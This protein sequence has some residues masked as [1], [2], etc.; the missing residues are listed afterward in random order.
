MTQTTV[1]D[2]TLGLT[3]ADRV[4]VSVT[5]LNA[6]VGV[7]GYGVQVTGNLG[8]EV[9]AATGTNDSRV[10][11]ASVGSGLGTTVAL[12]PVS[13][14]L[15][16]GALGV[17]QAFGK[18]SGGNS[19]TP[20]QDWTTVGR[21]FDVHLPD[22]DSV[23][24]GLR[25]RH[26]ARCRRSGPGCRD[27]LHAHPEPGEQQR[28]RPDR[29]RSVLRSLVN[30]LSGSIGGSGWGVT[31]SGNLTVAALAATGGDTRHWLA[32]YGNGLGLQVDLAP[33]TI[34]G[35]AAT[36]E[37]N[38][39]TG[40]T[41]VIS[42]WSTVGLSGLPPF[43][44]SGAYLDVNGT[45]T[46]ITIT[47]LGTISVPS[48]DLSRTDNLFTHPSGRNRP[49]RHTLHPH[50][51]RGSPSTRATR[52]PRPPLTIDNGNLVSPTRSR[53]GRTAGSPSR[54]LGFT[55]PRGELV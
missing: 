25:L 23:R 13:A 6:N 46:S 18:D 47:G 2:A 36:L 4:D 9:L 53:L 16:G 31:V 29:C 35:S 39:A 33:L 5:G 22:S 30:G 55:C 10:W 51:R 26:L 45:V 20:I 12:G 7:S 44:E 28:A 17:N 8:F 50:P 54:E 3:N 40:S 27:V 48:V 11:F 37:L 21:G 32:V 41:P 19:P 49:P 1:S 14:Q 24:H 34:T 38:Q 42:D 52:R 15:A 43:P